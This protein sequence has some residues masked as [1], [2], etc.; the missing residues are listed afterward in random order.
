MITNDHDDAAETRTVKSPSKGIM[1]LPEYG[2]IKPVSDGTEPG[3]VASE[4][5]LRQRQQ[6]ATWTEDI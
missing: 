1:T 2:A 6:V 4:R 5:N 3:T